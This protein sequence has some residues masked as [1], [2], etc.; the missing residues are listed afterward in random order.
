MNAPDAM[1]NPG[2]NP[3]LHPGSMREVA[4]ATLAETHAIRALAGCEAALLAL[5]DR[6][7]A[8]EIPSFEAEDALALH[9]AAREEHVARLR[10]L[11][12]AWSGAVA[13]SVGTPDASLAS[14]AAEIS[15]ALLE[16]ERSDARFAV[17]LAERRRVAAAEIGRA[18]AGRAAHRAYAPAAP[19]SAPRFTDRRG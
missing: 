1:K 6:A 14:I 11:D 12:G 4:E 7:A 9:L 19:A 17:E 5:V 13:R 16:I 15:A 18:D 2:A 10:A 8:G 3:G